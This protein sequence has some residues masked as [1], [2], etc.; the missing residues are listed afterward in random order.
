MDAPADIPIMHWIWLTILTGIVSNIGWELFTYFGHAAAHSLASAWH[1][2]RK[3]PSHVFSLHAPLRV[4]GVVLAA[5]A[6]VSFVQATGGY[7]FAAALMDLITFY[8]SVA[9]SV[10]D[11]LFAFIIDPN[12]RH[13]AYDAIVVGLIFVFI[14]WRTASGWRSYGEFQ[15]AHPG[16]D[17]LS[18]GAYFGL[19][20]LGGLG[21]VVLAL[22]VMNRLI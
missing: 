11:Q 17:S 19:H 10:G 5:L 1:E 9:H 4:A 7:V 8:R 16:E 18:F 14:I 12:T 20:L 22:T 21:A 15:A 2:F 3:L 6:V 13:I